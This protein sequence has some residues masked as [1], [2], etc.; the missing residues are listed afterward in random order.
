MTPQKGAVAWPH[1]RFV[2][3]KREGKELFED[4]LAYYTKKI[5]SYLNNMPLLLLQ[6][7]FISSIP[8]ATII[9]H[10]RHNRPSRERR[11]NPRGQGVHSRVCVPLKRAQLQL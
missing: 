6:F 11:I 3:L 7:D 2:L 10:R 1:K 4:M 9:R 8:C 5:Q